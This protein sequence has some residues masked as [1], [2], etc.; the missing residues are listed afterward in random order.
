MKIKA[1]VLR[2]TGHSAPFSESRPLSIEEVELDPP[3]A[4]EVLVRIKA[5]GLCHSDL[6]AINGERPKPTPIVIGHEAAGI[7]VELGA[8]VQGF[9]VGDHVVPTYVAS[10]GACEMCEVGRP[11]LCEPATASNAAGTLRDGTTR[12]HKN[13]IRINHHSGV[14]GFAE[15]AVI[16][17]EAL[18]K[19]D[20]SIAFEHAAL[21]GCGVITGVGAVVNT[22]GLKA[23]E[24]V[25]VVG[26][27][28][29]GLSAL[30]AA[31]A[32]GAGQVIAVDLSD[33][34]LAFAKEL[35]THHTVNASQLDCV[36]QVRRLTNG[37][38]HIAVE[39]AGSPRALSTAYALT[40]R[41]GITVTAGMPGP[42]AEVTLSHLSIAAEER[43]L[44]GSYMGSCVPGRD[45][46]RYMSLFKDG[47]LPV[48]RLHSRTIGFDEL[49][50]A[51]DRLD[52]AVTVREVLVP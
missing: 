3:Q 46:P 24:T 4:G 25:A 44:K 5:V 8:G 49:N 13:G 48:D 32:T 42:G 50:A 34:K 20:K 14:A 2:E 28:G 29:V 6:V 9:E 33:E 16:P 41:G 31:I 38:V 45:I 11:A 21:F 7:V 39:T 17:K 36:E 37:G 35:G 51:M 10:C 15:Y 22:A 19:I 27:G 1:A 12:L 18:V 30:M 47:K 23:G 26:L 40:R 52:K 43:T